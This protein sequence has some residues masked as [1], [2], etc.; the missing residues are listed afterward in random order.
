MAKKLQPFSVIDK[1]AFIRKA[2]VAVE[3][4]DVPTYQTVTWNIAYDRV[5]VISIPVAE[6]G[7]LSSTPGQYY[8]DEAQIMGGVEQQSKN[9]LQWLRNR[10]LESGATPDAIRLLSAHT[11]S[12]TK[13]EEANMAEKLKAKKTTVAKAPKSADAEGLKSAAKATPVGK[14]AGSTPV[15]RGNAEALAKARAARVTGPDT[16]KIKAVA[17]AKDLTSREG[18]FRRLMSE[19]A[20]S[21]KT[22]QE[23][24]DKG[25]AANRKYDAGCLKFLVDNNIVSVS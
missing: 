17:K 19:D 1:A 12:F 8:H 16:R 14:K 18:S 11:G 25:K 6:M 13:K 3:I 15:K 7:E 2:H 20:L 23:W 24:R 21:S 9:H 5:E 10:A 4:V 22:V